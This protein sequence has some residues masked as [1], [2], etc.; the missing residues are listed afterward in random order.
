MFALQ[1]FV[2]TYKSS[3]TSIRLEVHQCAKPGDS[4]V[5]RVRNHGVAQFLKTDC[6]HMLNVDSDIGFK[7]ED[8]DALL[9]RDC[10]IVG[11]LYAKKQLGEPV[12][13]LNMLPEIPTPDDT[14]LIEVKFVGTGFMLIARTVFEKMIAENEARRM[15]NKALLAKLESSVTKEEFQCL[16][17]A[18]AAQDIEHVDDSDGKLGTLWAFFDAGV[19]NGS[20]L[21]EDWRFCKN[22]RDM[23]GKIYADTRGILTHTGKASYPIAVPLPELEI[24]P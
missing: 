12:W 10:D 11:G 17:K 2:L 14:G 6:T 20:F 18:F 4:H 24:K 19:E 1:R 21:T 15:K 5:D 13:V 3:D 22:W 7:P 9:A 16:E 8:I 23:G